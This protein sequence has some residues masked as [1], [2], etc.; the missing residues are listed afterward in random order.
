MKARILVAEDEEGIRQGIAKALERD[1]HEVEVV[2]DGLAALERLESDCFDLLITDVRMPKLDG[3]ELL[4]KA[5]TIDPDLIVI[6]IT[7]YGSIQDAVEAI[8]SGAYDYITK[9]I[10][11]GELRAVVEKALE[12]HRLAVE[13]RRLRELIKEEDRFESMIGTN[14][15]MREV[16]ELINKVASTNATVLIQG[17]TGTGKELV[18]RAIHNRSSRK[19]KPFISINCGAL[20][21]SLLEAELFGFEKGAFTG[22]YQRRIGK[23]ELADGGTL[24]LDEIGEMSLKTQVEFLRVLDQRELF[25]VGGSRPIKVD[26]RFIAATNSDL[27]KAVQEGRFRE[28]LYHRL[29]VFPITLPPLRE[30]VE[31]I[32]ILAMAFLEEFCKEYGRPPMK[33]S[34]EAMKILCSYRWPGNVRELKNIMERVALTC[35][36]EVVRPEHLP[37]E[38]R[39]GETEEEVR[40][41]VGTTVREAERILILK[42]LACVGGHR[43]KAAEIL[44]ISVRALYYK[45]R[46]YEKEGKA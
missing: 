29:N 24:F 9:P 40:I 36:D 15:K 13:N 32:P 44:G 2:A 27:K 37:Q 43:K 18:A 25:R 3:I 4:R 42:T 20:P 28:D 23:I 14:P 6:L 26:V 30:R 22:A 46:R 16:F 31:D 21:E 7:A 33:I 34:R 39:M 38:I 35:P 17:E 11:L 19:D 41:P 10:R 1:G 8:R 45:L 12:V 5:K